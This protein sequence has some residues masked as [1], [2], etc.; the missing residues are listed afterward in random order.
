MPLHSFL[1]FFFSSAWV[2]VSFL[3]LWISIFYQIWNIFGHYYFKY[4]FHP[5]PFWVFNYPYVRLIV[6]F[7][8]SIDALFV[9]ILLFFFLC[10]SFCIIY[11]AVFISSLTFSSESFFCFWSHLVWF[12]FHVLS[13]S[14]L[15][16]QFSFFI[17]H[18]S[19]QHFMLSYM[20]FT[21]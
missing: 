16:V 20:F 15:E 18:F 9:L 19:P 6:I 1:F 21:I 3:D 11:I 4:F 8:Q 7:P 5:S 2:V 10:I 12:L 17:F 14:V 13:F